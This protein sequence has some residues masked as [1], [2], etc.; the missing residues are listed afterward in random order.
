MLTKL[1]AH[2][3]GQYLGAIALFVALG[4][5]TYA[6]TSLP[7]SSV[8][9]RQLHNGAVTAKKLATSSVTN[10]KLASGS[11]GPGKLDPKSFAGYMRAYVQINAQGQVTASRPSAKMI[12]WTS[13][14]GGVIE[15][16]IDWS[17]PIPSSCFP[18]A[19]TSDFGNAS[20]ASAMLAG[21]SK[22]NAVTYVSL[23]PPVQ[24][25]SIAIMCPPS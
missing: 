19:T 16:T 9:N 7:T 2:L 17:Q 24:P 6:A 5:T 23:S 1:L 4:G 13:T 22:G 18:L 8:G 14:A 21:G 20:Y 25:V 11:V 3:R 10:R 15:G 12:A